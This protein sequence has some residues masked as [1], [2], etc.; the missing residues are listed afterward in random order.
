MSGGG[1][2][3][4]SVTQEFKPPEYTRS[5]WQ[6]YL[7]ASKVLSQRPYEQ[8]GLPQV[9]PMNDYQDAANKLAY[10]LGTYGTPQ[11]NAA[12]GAFYNAA[13]GAYA[14]PWAQ[15][16]TGLAMGEGGN[17]ALG[18]YEQMANMGPNPYTS[19]AYTNQMVKDSTDSMANAYAIGDAA[20]MSAAAAR[21][22]AFGGSAHD[23]RAQ[24]GAAGLAKAVGQNTNQLLGQQQQYKG[25]MY[26]QD[27]SNRMGALG[28][29]ANTYN[30]DIA[31]MMGANAQGGQMYQNDI[32][33]ILAGAQGGLAGNQDYRQNLQGLMQAGNNQNSYYQKLLDQYNNQWATQEG[34]DALQ[35]DMFGTA[36]SRASGSYGGQTTNT[37]GQSPWANVAGLLAG[38]AGM[39]S[40]FKP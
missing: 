12:N 34:Y 11:G 18:G 2:G 13:S 14:N 21:S 5:G 39:Y 38:G 9:A 32:G 6:Q 16:L 33:N 36:L 26:N 8:S 40:L 37:P 10:D 35:N 23:Q 25:N 17:P 4:Q 24:S 22:G 7:D 31:N 30:Q 15:N 3:N 29:Y 19:D 1:G 27:F 28:G 20:N